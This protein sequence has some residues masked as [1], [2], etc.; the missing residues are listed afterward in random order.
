MTSEPLGA[1]VPPSRTVLALP[2]LEGRLGALKNFNDDG[3]DCRR[4]NPA[5]DVVECVGRLPVVYVAGNHVFYDR[6]WESARRAI[7]A[8]CAGTRVT[9][10]DNDAFETGG[11]RILGCTQWTDFEQRGIEQAHAMSTAERSLMDCHV[12]RTVSGLLR[13]QQTLADHKQ[14]RAWLEGE[15]AKPSTER[16]S[17][18]RTMGRIR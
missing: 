8:A 11:D 10:L 5:R 9:F 7:R 18:S 13:A 1:S 4:L 12:I 14:S 3:L 6:D 15:L 16:L 2:I 17:L